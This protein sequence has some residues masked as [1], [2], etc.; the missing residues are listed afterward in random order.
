MKGS[1]KDKFMAEGLQLSHIL[2]IFILV[3]KA[4]YTCS[5]KDR[6]QI[7]QIEQGPSKQL[8]PSSMETALES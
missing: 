6:N 8:K 4:Y 7:I 2:V 1:T 3:D 5:P